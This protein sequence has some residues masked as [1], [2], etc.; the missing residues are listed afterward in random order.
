MAIDVTCRR[1]KAELQEPGALV[2]SP[3]MEAGMVVKHH[4]CV[5]CWKVVAEIV[6]T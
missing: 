6:V 2:F 3:P 4:L 5:K 1:C